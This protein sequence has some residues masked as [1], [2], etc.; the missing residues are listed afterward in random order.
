M[1]NF[2]EINVLGGICDSTIGRS[3]TV[4]SPTVSIKTSLQG[5]MFSVTYTTVVNLASVYEMRALA[6][7]YE[8]ESIGVIKEYIKHVKKDFKSEAGRSLKIKEE[9]SNDSFD[10]ITTSPFSPRRTA[11]YKRTSSFRVG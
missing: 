9:F 11:Y 10:V 8:E 3:S 1:L 4:K 6:K 7:R 2:H 5:D